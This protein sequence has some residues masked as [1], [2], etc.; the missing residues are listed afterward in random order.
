[1][2]ARLTGPFW[3]QRETSDSYVACVYDGHKLVDAK[4][5]V[6]TIDRVNLLLQE[7]LLL[8]NVLSGAEVLNHDLWNCGCDTLNLA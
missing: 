8:Y 4:S 2:C 3:L 6:W 7:L 5:R 1:M